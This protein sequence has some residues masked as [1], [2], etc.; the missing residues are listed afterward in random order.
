MRKDKLIGGT[1]LG[2]ISILF[3]SGPALAQFHHVSGRVT[4]PRGSGVW[5]VD[6]DV[7][8]S[9][10]GI[11]LDITNDHTDPNGDYD[12][13][14]PTGTF[15]IEYNAPPGVKLVSEIR[16][17]V[18]VQNDLVIDIVF[19]DGFYLSGRVT[20]NLGA[21]VNQVDID[22]D[23]VVTGLRIIT[24]RDN[25][26][27]NGDYQ[28]V[29]PAGLFNITSEPPPGVRLAAAIHRDVE[30]SGDMVLNFTLED[31]YFV[32]GWVVDEG[33]IGLLDID[34]DAD[35]LETGESVPTPERQHR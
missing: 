34:L 16:R 35:D 33:G 4:D 20:N 22:V 15:N 14:L 13:V 3:I 28:V 18:L 10:T 25:T 27:I 8:D 31:G 17:F 11:P 5:G 6:I 7:E 24:P 19:E 21:G 23:D 29:V 12:I 2:V 26:D 32:S 1:A 9:I 30:I